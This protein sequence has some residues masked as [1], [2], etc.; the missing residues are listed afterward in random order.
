M[1]IAQGILQSLTANLWNI[2]EAACRRNEVG[3]W[4]Q[5]GTGIIYGPYSFFLF[6]G[7]RRN[8]RGLGRVFIIDA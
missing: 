7:G 2:G 8:E 4:Q 6:A 3:E 1:Q 5:R